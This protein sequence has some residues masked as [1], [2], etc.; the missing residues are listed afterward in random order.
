MQCLPSRLLIRRAKQ[1]LHDR[2][3]SKRL[4]RQYFPRGTDL[5]GY[6]QA[7]LDQVSP[8]SNQRPRKT[9]GFQTPA[10]SLRASVATTVRAGTIYQDLGTQFKNDTLLQPDR[11]LACGHRPN[12]R[13][14][15]RN[16]RVSCMKP[17]SRHPRT[18]REPNPR[19]DT[20]SNY[21]RGKPA[22]AR[23][24]PWLRCR[25]LE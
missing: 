16:V 7:Q 19:Q 18:S 11:P 21:P 17:V 2:E 10:S 3:S 13:S 8:R 14:S 15:L 22:A 1:K 12:L 20:Y 25:C 4:L 23:Q 24:R 6:S 5:S 9:S